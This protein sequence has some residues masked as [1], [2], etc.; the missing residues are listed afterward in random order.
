[1]S[2]ACWHLLSHNNLI[3]TVAFIYQKSAFTC[4]TIMCYVHELCL[5]NKSY[6]YLI[7]NKFVTVRLLH[8]LT[9]SISTQLIPICAA[10]RPAYNTHVTPNLYSKLQ[11]FQCFGA[12]SQSF[13][14]YKL[15]QFSNINRQINPKKK[16]TP[17]V[18]CTYSTPF[19][20]TLPY[21]HSRLNTPFN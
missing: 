9:V 21:L 17:D 16:L 8:N 10:C 19:P 14:T 11:N 3:V 7:N 6:V 15:S 5:I 18:L 13:Y 12:E 20:I 4:L 1:M 2:I